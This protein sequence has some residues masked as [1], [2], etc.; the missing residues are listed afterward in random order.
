[1]VGVIASLALFFI[2]HIAYP[3]GASGA[4][5]YNPDWAALLLALAA[6]VALMRFKLGVIKVIVLCA[7]AG[8]ALHPWAGLTA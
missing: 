1:V 7:P 8:W 3:M 6:G 5:P 2:A 4:F